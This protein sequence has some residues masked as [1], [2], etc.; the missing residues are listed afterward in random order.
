M[1]L[2]EYE[3][4]ASA[5]DEEFWSRHRD[6]DPATRERVERLR[7]CRPFWIRDDDG[8]A[9]RRW[10]VA[11]RVAALYAVWIDVDHEREAAIFIWHCARSLYRSEIPVD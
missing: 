9:V 8:P 5:A 11:W 3:G 2:V 4:G 10:A 6:V 1:E 7:P